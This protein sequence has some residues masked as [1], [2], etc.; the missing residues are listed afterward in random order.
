M[1]ALQRVI[2]NS[3]VE[4]QLAQ[5]D[6]VHQQEGAADA[7]LT[8]KQMKAA[9]AWAAGEKLGVEAINALQEKLGVA[10]SGVYDEATATGVYRQQREWKPKGRIHNAGKADASVFTRLGLIRTRTI[11][12]AR[13]ADDDLERIKKDFPTGVTVAIYPQYDYGSAKVRQNNKEFYTQSNLFAANNNVVGLS[14]GDITRGHP[15]PIHDLAEVIETVQSIHRGLAER[16][17]QSLPPDRRDGP[18]PAFTRIKNLALFAHGEPYG[19]GLNKTNRYELLSIQKQ[20]RAANIHAFVQGLSGAVAADV[21]V[22][23]FACNTARE[24]KYAKEQYVDWEGHK[25]GERRGAGSFAAQ[26]AEELGPEA[27]VFGHTTAGHTTENYAAT[28]FGKIVGGEGGLHLFDLM[29][30]ESFIMS[31]LTRL[32]PDLSQEDRIALHDKLRDE[33]WRHYKDSVHG[34]AHGRKVRDPK[35]HG[36]KIVDKSKRYTSGTPPLG[37]E[38]FLNPEHARELFQENW[39]SVWMTDARRKGML[40]T[41]GNDRLERISQPGS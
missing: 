14:G 35:Q 6:H 3:A 11:V 22:Q 23:L 13:V 24:P 25:Q 36:K 16:Y 5:R 37:Q 40:P 34:E 4:R 1:L 8:D 20:L 39:K 10:V 29:Y 41:P 38:M 31:E 27:S 17:R 32:F 18:L 26:L 15:I 12:A 30:P 19:M 9:L 2:G 7:D 21:N 28:A 33:M